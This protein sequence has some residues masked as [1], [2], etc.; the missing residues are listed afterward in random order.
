MKVFLSSTAQDLDAYRRVADNTILS[1]S[2]QAVVMERFGPL[3][4]T[5]VDECERLARESDVVVCIVAHRYGFVPEQDRGSITQREIEA[6]HKAGKDVLVWIVA[7]DQ[8][9]TEKKEQDLLV[10][11]NVLGDP[12]R[13]EAVR[14]GVKGLI[15]FKAWLRTTFTPDTFTTPDDL[16]KRIAVALANYLAGRAA[17]PVPKDKISLARLPTGGSELFGREKELQLLDEA[18]ANPNTNIVSFVAWGGVGKTALI[19]HWLKQR[20][21]RDNYRGADRVYGWSFFSQ[22]T[23]ERAASADLFIDQALRWFG[24]TDP[25]QGSPWDKGERLAGYIRQSRTLLI[26]DGLEPLQHPPGPQEGRLKDAAIQALL[27]EL[28]AQQ[29]GLCVIS[30]RERIGDLVEFENSTVVRHDLEHLSPKA[31]AQILRSLNVKG[32]T[33][34]LEEASRELKG[35]A[36][37]L[38]LLGS[39]L[40]EVLQGDIRRRKE[41]EN[42]F[43]D[44]RYGGAAQEMI[45]AYETWLGEGMEL[46]ILRLLGLFD[47]PAEAASIAALREAPVVVGL[48]EPLQHFKAREWN[49]AVAKL[50]RV[51]LLGEASPNEPATLDA[52]P[53]VREHFKQQLKR[54]RPD[55]WLEGNNRIYEHL[56]ITTKEFPATLEELSPLFA[57]VAHG[58]AAGRHQ[59]ALNRVF[60]QRIQRGSEPYSIYQLGAFSANLATLAC[61]FEK[62]WSAPREELDE[63]SKGFVR[64]AAGFCLRAIG[65]STEAL[66]PIQAALQICLDGNDWAN[67]AT[68]AANLSELYLTAGQLASGIEFAARSVELA[69]Q[70]NNERTKVDSLNGLAYARYQAGDI[71]AALSAFESAEVMQRRIVPEFPFLF[72]QRGFRYCELLLAEMRLEEVKERATR[73]L[74]YGKEQGLGPLSIALDHLSLGQACLLDTQM[75]GVSDTPRA[76]ELLQRA[77]AGLRLA[78]QVHELPRGLLA[79]AVLYRITGDYEEAARD[80]AEVLR[81]ATRS[82]MRLHLAD[83]HLESARLRLAQDNNDKA[84]EHLTTAKEMI[85]RMGYHRRDKEVDALEQQL[86]PVPNRER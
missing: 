16:G 5:P 30:T 57:A 19:N 84:R 55:A 47:R 68:A 1:L 79:R 52:H 41:I 56:Q 62:P 72:S 59:D 83:Y 50:R 31:G 28:A 22:G 32:E 37:S 85:E 65:R 20:M 48:T 17:P 69:N 24:D 4:G 2:Q 53:L 42:L 78:G 46:A 54:E 33:E 63:Y 77:V 71:A 35:H 21:A 3:P 60:Q 18:W 86:G 67:A 38:T 51:K 15:D 43:D 44:T 39:Y 76:A 11:P 73:T 66:Q 27:V 14:D 29:N 13:F 49:Q 45:A 82:G 25:T 81:I 34:E 8:P 40:D 7:E 23:S 64:H 75:N 80:L 12:A 6:A 61:F 36:F 10:D 74:E 9:W 70:G 26:L 58:C